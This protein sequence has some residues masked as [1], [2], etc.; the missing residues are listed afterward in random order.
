MRAKL[1]GE[2]KFAGGNVSKTKV[3]K[4]WLFEA[5]QGKIRWNKKSFFCVD[6]SKTKVGKNF[7]LCQCEQN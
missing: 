6:V 4:Q 2:T 1:E 3:G 7:C 5:M